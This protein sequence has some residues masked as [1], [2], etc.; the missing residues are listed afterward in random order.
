MTPAEQ[1][2]NEGV[3]AVLSLARETAVTMQTSSKPHHVKTRAAIAAL[4]ALADN[5]EAL[6]IGAKS[7]GS[8][9]TKSPCGDAEPDDAI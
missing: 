5:A 8:T 1:A 6:L 2:Y 4:C 7:N 9:G 3:R